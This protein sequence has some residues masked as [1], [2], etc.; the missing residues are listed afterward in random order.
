MDTC[1]VCPKTIEDNRKY[2]SKSCYGKDISKSVDKECPVCGEKFTTTPSKDKVYCTKKCSGKANR[3]GKYIECDNCGKSVWKEQNVIKRNSNSYCSPDCHNKDQQLEDIECKYC[4]KEFT[5][6]ESSVKY[7]SRQC[8]G[9][10]KKK[11]STVPCSNCGNSVTRWD[12]YIEKYDNIFCNH[13]CR[14]NWLEENSL[15]A[16]D[17]PNKKEKT[18][19]KFGEN[20]KEW[21]KKILNRSQGYCENCGKTGNEN[22]RSLSVHH[23]EPRSKFI[24]DD[25][26]CVEDS[27]NYENLVALCQTCHSKAEHNKILIE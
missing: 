2:C 20:W 13:D 4:E 7:C 14:S 12:Y 5:P 3:N 6:T 21:R 19:L 10:D 15:F 1:K 22:G 16:T 24:N 18:F 23:K 25:S 8:S 11:R 17:N 27:N 26:K 9:K